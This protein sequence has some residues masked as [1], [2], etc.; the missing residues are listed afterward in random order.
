MTCSESQSQDNTTQCV[1]VCV[2]T[3]ATVEPGYSDSDFL[4]A[5]RSGAADWLMGGVEWDDRTAS[6]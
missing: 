5:D 3:H 4:S 6:E 1:R 2:L